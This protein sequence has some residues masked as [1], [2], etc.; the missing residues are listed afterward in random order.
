MQKK[1]YNKLFAVDSVGYALL[2]AIAATLLLW[3][4]CKGFAWLYN[5]TPWWIKLIGASIFCYF[6][7][8]Q[9]RVDQEE[10]NKRDQEEPTDE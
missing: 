1:I 8:R 7:Y 2:S 3:G 9:L 5:V 4:L 6:L 10:Q